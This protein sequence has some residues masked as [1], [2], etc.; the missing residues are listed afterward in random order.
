LVPAAL[1]YPLYASGVVALVVLPGVPAGRWYAV[2]ARGALFG[3]VAYGTYDLT[4]QATLRAWPVWL[5]VLDMAWGTV[6]T[7]IVA[8]LA[9]AIATRVAHRG[10]NRV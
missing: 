3:V 6:L 10:P 5:T 1:F 9:H 4:N 8:A 7:A 2:V